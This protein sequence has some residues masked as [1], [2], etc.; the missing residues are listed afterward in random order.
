L[1]RLLAVEVSAVDERRR[2]SLARFASLPS[3]F[4][5]ADF[6]FSAQPSVDKKLIDE[7]ATLRFV[8]DATNVLA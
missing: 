6:D 1:E 3:P 2:A 4:T 7:L 5:S 8:E